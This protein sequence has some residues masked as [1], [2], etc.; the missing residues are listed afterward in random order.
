MKKVKSFLTVVGL[1]MVTAIAS[2]NV[3]GQ[4]CG[5]PTYDQVNPDFY[6]SRTV[7][8]SIHIVHENSIND[9]TMISNDSL[10][11]AF[12]TAHVANINH[13]LKN[14]EAANH[15]NHTNISKTDLKLQVEVYN[16][17]HHVDAELNTGYYNNGSKMHYST[18]LTQAHS[19]LVV[20]NANITQYEKDNVLP[21]YYYGSTDAK[22]FGGAASAYRG[23]QFEARKPEFDWWKAYHNTPNGPGGTILLFNY[24][25]LAGNFI[26]EL[27]HCFGLQHNFYYVNS[28]GGIVQEPY[29]CDYT[30][31]TTPATKWHFGNPIHTQ[32]FP[33]SYGYLPNN[34]MYKYEGPNPNYSPNRHSISYCQLQR[35]LW[36][37]YNLN[38]GT[39]NQSNITRCLKPLQT[40]MNSHETTI[41][42][43]VF[44]DYNMDAYGD[45]IV[46]NGA[47]LTVSCTLRMP[48]NSKIIVE[49]GG[50]LIVDGGTI[51]NSCGEFWEGIEVVGNKNIAQQYNYQGT[52]VLNNAMI[53]NALTGVAT[54]RQNHYSTS[55]AIIEATNTTFLNNV[56]GV[57]FIKYNAALINGREPDNKSFFK[58]CNFIW[59]KDYPDEDYTPI[60]GISAHE[61]R[62]LKVEGC[63]LKIEDA[64]ISYYPTW[65]NKPHGLVGVNN[66]FQ[67]KNNVFKNLGY[68]IHSHSSPHRGSRVKSNNFENCAA[69]VYLADD[70]FSSFSYN[71]IDDSETGI[72]VQKSMGY[73]ITENY[74]INGQSNYSVGVNFQN[75]GP[76]S[77][78]IYNNIFNNTARGIQ[79]QGLQLNQSNMGLSIKCNEFTSSMSTA[80]ILVSSGTIDPVQGICNDG[81]LDETTVPAGNE[82][83]HTCTY[84]ISDI[85]VNNTSLN[86]IRYNHHFQQDPDP[87]EPNCYSTNVTFAKECVATPKN[88]IDRCPTRVFGQAQVSGDFTVYTN[89]KHDIY[90]ERRTDAINKKADFTGNVLDGGNTQQVLDEVINSIS[91]GVN[92]KAYLDQ[93]SPYLSDAV[94]LAAIE[95]GTFNNAT[96]L[97]NV[98]LD[99]SRLSAALQPLISGLGE[100]GLTTDQI[101]NLLAAQTG[102]SARQ[103]KELEIRYHEQQAELAL[104]DLLR[105]FA[106]DSLAPEPTDTMIFYLEEWNS[107]HTYD[108][109]VQLH[110]QKGNYT[111]AQGYINSLLDTPMYNSLGVV[112]QKMHDMYAESDS[113]PVLLSD[114]LLLDSIASDSNTSGSSMARNLMWLLTKKSYSLSPEEYYAASYKRD[115]NAK[116]S[117]ITETE[118]WSGFSVF[119]NPNNGTFEFTW[120]LEEDFD[121]LNINVSDVLGK[122]VIDKNIQSKQGKQVYTLTN[123][124]SGIYLLKVSKNNNVVYHNK[125][126]IS[127]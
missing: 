119:P 21:I 94:L 5:A 33:G 69:G 87:F 126:V 99:N 35:V 109:L 22:D 66:S 49:R 96:E 24:D 123:P 72:I 117:L 9:N 91:S 23:I 127:E 3:A 32:P 28:S 110:W 93:F 16:I 18:R 84:S 63:T 85:L 38:N 121:V 14:L 45:I 88:K 17:H 13:Y 76:Y 7:R 2:L 104:N 19:R 61:I 6:P 39:I 83:S 44:I 51:T 62:N 64:D 90:R 105:K 1:T 43:D 107:I 122:T 47:T 101:D 124:K 112:L 29:G 58:N 106:L 12:L 120:D 73:E 30:L 111:A 46:N 77:S 98:L 92:L 100:Y 74:F 36:N 113:L 118:Q 25:K 95:Y 114:T 103:E 78:Q 53:E 86:L 80:D 102:V 52:V 4:T 65:N 108:E 75:S 37:A 82:F 8:I 11:N 48:E 54:W 97:Y 27:T 89:D 41:N 34:F 10:G 59:N 50:K 42:S 67:A 115:P 116:P 60:A 31:P 40:C 26:H 125:L 56:L 20:N 79:A 15:F 57:D 71:I 55:G 81:Q 68:G 70:N